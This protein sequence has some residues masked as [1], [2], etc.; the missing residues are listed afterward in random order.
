MMRT[1]SLGLLAGALA[2]GTPGWA[3]D[4]NELRTRLDRAIAAFDSA[5]IERAVTLLRSLTTEFQP[6][7]PV[8]LRVATHLLLGEA[9]WSLGFADSA[10][11][12]FGTAVERDP[13]VK[14]DADLHNP[15]LREAFSRA[16]RS[17]IAL[18]LRVPRDTV[19]KPDSES[20]PVVLAVG[21]PGTVEM[22]L[23]RV[24]PAG[25]DTLLAAI[26][27]DSVETFSLRFESGD[28]VPARLR[29]YVLVAWVAAEGSADTAVVRFRVERQPVDTAA[30]EPPLDPSRFRPEVRKGSPPLSSILRGALVG[31]AAA[32]IPVIV[33]SKD[34]GNDDLELRAVAVGATITVAGLA[35]LVLGRPELPI[36]E[37]VVYNR[38]IRSGWER[39]NHMIARENAM[40][41]RLAPLRFRVLKSP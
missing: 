20:W 2:L 19:L 8:D 26:S 14:L 6:T 38:D 41:I 5:Q 18:G 27:V 24:R 29:E 25:R 22:R 31:A 32:A 11:R 23:R 35:G 17:T 40:K 33:T 12:H 7:V 1:V 39:R 15:E 9:Y 21:R 13:F 3:Q 36:E 28:T 34:L 30:H 37:N 4:P 16:K 10:L